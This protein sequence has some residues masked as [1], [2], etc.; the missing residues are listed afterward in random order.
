MQAIQPSTVRK[1]YESLNKSQTQSPLLLLHDNGGLDNPIYEPTVNRPGLALAGFTKHF[2]FRRIQAFGR[3]EI[4]F[5]QSLS[6]RQQDECCQK[7]FRYKIPCLIFC[8]NI[9]PPEKLL[10]AAKL[11]KTP[12]FSTPLVTGSFINHATHYLDDLFAPR[13]I[14]TGC[15][16]DIQGVGILIKGE[17][18][19]GKSECVLA[20][21]GKGYCLVSDDVTSLKVDEG[22]TLLGNP[23]DGFGGFMEVRGIG[24]IN[25]A[26]MFGI[27]SIRANKALDLVVTLR[28]FEDMGCD[29]E[30]LGRT[31]EDIIEILGVKIPHIILPISAG[32]DTARMVEVAAL[33]KK[34]T[35]YGREPALDQ[36]SKRL[37]SKMSKNNSKNN[38]A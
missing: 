10:K 2:A 34:L 21:L 13:R 35:D 4:A 16:V 11:A 36:F 25:V 26:E 28:K 30:R 31:Q 23:I 14:E 32:R 24:L 18:G 22:N 17:S 1:F 27:K 6:N 33:S 37:S 8:R 3:A 38:G 20:L 29:I 9:T 19:I 12:T 5:F 7:L 15:M